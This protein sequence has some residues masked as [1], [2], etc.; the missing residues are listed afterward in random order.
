MPRLIVM[1]LLAMGLMLSVGCAG[2]QSLRE[3]ILGASGVD[4]F[5]RI[6]QLR[7]TIRVERDGEVEARREWIWRPDE[8]QVTLAYEED[9]ASKKL[10]YKRGLL[11]PES[12]DKYTR[13]DR[14]FISDTLK[15][16][17]PL[18]LSWNND[19]EVVDRGMA[20]APVTGEAARQVDVVYPVEAGR[21]GDVYELF[22]DGRDRIVAWRLRPRGGAEIAT[23]MALSSYQHFGPLWIATEQHEA[24]VNQRLHFSGIT[25]TQHNGLSGAWRDVKLCPTGRGYVW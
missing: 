8:G 12:E 25:V 13:A 2:P 18:R 20:R 15:L 11:T 9:G 14:W 24:Q 22:L 23:A 7:Y 19:L 17:P 4:Q 1:A 21:A 16:L 3:R 10:V 5:G 6:E